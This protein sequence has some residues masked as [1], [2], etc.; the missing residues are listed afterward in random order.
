MALVYGTLEQLAMFD[1]RVK[2]GPWSTLYDAIK[3]DLINYGGAFV[4]DGDTK[5]WGL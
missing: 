1:I 4:T 3:Q 5:P 2:T